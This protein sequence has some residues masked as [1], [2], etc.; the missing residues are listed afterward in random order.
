MTCVEVDGVR[1][2]ATLLLCHVAM[3]ALRAPNE[4][5]IALLRSTERHLLKD[6]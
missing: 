6:P 1:R 2:D 5:V 4:S 3:P